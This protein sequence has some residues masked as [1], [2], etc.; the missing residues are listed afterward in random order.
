M[1]KFVILKAEDAKPMEA[2]ITSQS[3]TAPT[4][5]NYAIGSTL[6]LTGAKVT[7]NYDIKDTEVVDVTT[8]MLDATTIPAFDT[9]GT[10][11]ITGNYNGYAFSF[12]VVVSDKAITSIA[13]EANPTKTTYT[14]RDGL[15]NLDLAGGKLRVTYSTG[16]SEVVDMDASM[17][18]ATDENWAVGTVNYTL[19][20]FGYT[21]TLAITDAN[22]ADTV[23]QILQRT[24]DMVYASKTDG[25]KY[26]AP[27][28]V[29]E[30]TGVVVRVITDYESP[31]LLIRE[32][33]TNNV[34]GIKGDEA[35]VGKYNAPALN[36]NVVNIGDEIAIYVT[37][38]KCLDDSASIG[39]RGKTYLRAQSNDFTKSSIVVLSK[40]NSTDLPLTDSD[41]TIIDSQEDLV[42]FINNPNRFY[43]YVKLVGINFVRSDGK[44]QNMMY[45]DSVSTEDGAR[46]N[47]IFARV[48]QHNFSGLTKNTFDKHLSTVNGT[49]TSP[50]TAKTDFYMLFVGGNSAAHHFV[51]LQDSWLLSK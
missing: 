39:L 50:A 46:I 19:T 27:T 9:A 31:E 22:T 15:A 38:E 2:T 37:L 41:V 47:G 8:D 49:Y 43:S 7:T 4:V 13:I 26:V 16:D 25:S 5:V 18:P 36:T 11:T 33:G 44:N 34:I 24:P 21:A 30:V 29:Y 20:Y 17:L 32:K 48:S 10:F 35:T 23:S 51:P 42:A 6:N 12:D 40:G 1:N 28:N 14:H 3:F 45:K